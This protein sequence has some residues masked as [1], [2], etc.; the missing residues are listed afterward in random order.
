M[1]TEFSPRWGPAFFFH[2]S[3]LHGLSYNLVQIPIAAFEISIKY[4]LCVSVK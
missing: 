2:L 4:R 3:F 1:F